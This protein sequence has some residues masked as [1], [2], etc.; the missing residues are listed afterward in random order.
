MNHPSVGLGVIVTRGGEV[1]LVRRRNVHGDGTWS[2]PGGH[3]DFGETPEECAAREVFEETGVTIAD[4]AFRA[5]TSD[6]FHAQGRHY[7]T[8]WF[9]ARHVSGEGIVEAPEEIAEVGWFTWNALPAPL[10]LCFENLLAGR[11][12]PR[13]AHPATG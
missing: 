12:Y 3:I 13:P 2:T 7:V 5:M 1:L 4:I 10:F 9:D 11:C 8:L 6:V